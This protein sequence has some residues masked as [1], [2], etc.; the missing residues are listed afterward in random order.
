MRTIAADRA[1]VGR[2]RA[3]GQAHAREDAHIGGV[4]LVVARLGAFH[5]A[6]EGIGVLHREFAPAHDAEARPAFVTELGL[7]VIPVDRQLAVALDLLARDVGDHLFR[8][9]LD[10]EI[11][12]MAIFDAQQLRAVLLPTTRFLPELGGLH[13]RHQQLD[14]P[15]AVHLLA[16]DLFDL[17]NR[18]QA[19]GHVVVNARGELFDHAGAQHEFLRHHFGVGG[20]FFE[21]GNEELGGFHRTRPRAGR[22]GE[23]ASPESV[24]SCGKARKDA[25]NFVL[26]IDS[27]LNKCRWCDA[28]P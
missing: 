19:H 20:R 2:D 3:E 5:V 11:A 1:G 14:R 24:T 9:R 28:R 15:G 26:I 4:H 21:R 18:A 22:A 7:D 13:H 12:V 6:V 16:D 10:D 17:A 23:F 8:G 27:I 25:G